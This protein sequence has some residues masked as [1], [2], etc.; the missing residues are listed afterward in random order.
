M[1]NRIIIIL[2]KLF[3]QECSQNQFQIIFLT[4]MIHHKN[5]SNNPTSQTIKKKFSQPLTKLKKYVNERWMKQWQLQLLKA[6]NIFFNS[7]SIK[8]HLF[9]FVLSIKISHYLIL[10]DNFAKL[11]MNLA[12]VISQTVA[13]TKILS[14]IKKRILHLHQ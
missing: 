9:I 14:I 7:F 6:I 1:G 12:K 8:L 11:R 3:F 13:Q 2:L 10:Y 4:I 5:I